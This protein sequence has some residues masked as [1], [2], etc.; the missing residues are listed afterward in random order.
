VRLLELL[1]STTFRWA[2][3]TAAAFAVGNLLLFGGFYLRTTVYLRNNIDTAVAEAAHL[4]ASL[5]P[6]E[7]LKSIDRRLH[8]DP[9]HVRLAGLFGADGKRIFGNIETFPAALALDGSAHEAN[10]LRIDSN[11]TESQMAR[12]VGVRLGNRD[13]LIVG[14]DADELR[15]IRDTIDQGMI[16]ALLPALMLALAVG[17]W[18]S[19]RVQR[20]I[21]AMGR[22]ASRIVSGE[23][24][25][26]LPIRHS[27]DPLDRLASIVNR[28]LDE[29]EELI[30]QLAGVGDDIAHD[31]RT[32]LTRVRAMLE[33]GRDGTLAADEMRALN[34]RAIVGLDQSLA[35]VTALLRIAEIDH[36]RRLA[37]IDIVRLAEIVTA[38]Q[39]FY[40][41]SAEDKGVTLKVSLAE[42]T[43]IPGDRDL[44]FEAVAN[45]VDNAMKFTPAG[46]TVRI[47]LVQR[48]DGPVVRVEDTGPGIDQAE[49][50][51]VVRRFYRSD[52]SRGTA[53]VGLGLSLVAAIVKLHGF[54]LDI[55]AGPG[56][57]VEIVCRPGHPATLRHAV[58]MSLPR[59]GASP[60][61][62]AAT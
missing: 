17:A 58:A 57:V 15:Q 7:M 24:Q 46:G 8:D 33:R 6:D 54:S 43:P 47:S 28:M 2:L 3:I 61:D 52:K 38:V 19:L 53:G 25:A 32:P 42:V 10:L 22:Q 55:S 23:L 11:G 21:E 62:V 39:E 36:G 45:L 56:C 40:A 9:R 30:G 1:R 13:V 12:A 4:L 26:R 37:G 49:R 5:P 41:P 31:I 59:A 27:R 50:D 44:L 35:V 34:D 16:L 48:H 14:R 51:A 20:R 29:I 60:A 18:L